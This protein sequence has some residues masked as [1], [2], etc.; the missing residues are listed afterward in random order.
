MR[1]SSLARVRALVALCPLRR[2]VTRTFAWLSEM[3]LF[4]CKAEGCGGFWSILGALKFP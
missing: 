4:Y 3:C 2:P 1:E